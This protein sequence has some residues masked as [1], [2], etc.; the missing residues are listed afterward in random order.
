[1]LV[2]NSACIPLLLTSPSTTQD[3]R[4][5]PKETDDGSTA[6]VAK[7]LQR[8]SIKICTPGSPCRTF[9]SEED[10]PDISRQIFFLGS[11]WMWPIFVTAARAVNSPTDPNQHEHH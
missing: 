4:A 8:N 1:M 5:K 6:G 9:W 7:V 11:H 3:V 2:F 10:T